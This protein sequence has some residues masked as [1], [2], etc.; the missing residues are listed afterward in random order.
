MLK[1]SGN[2]V[3]PAEIAA[4][5]I[6][7]GQAQEAEVIG[8]KSETGETQ[9]I[10]FV[11]P[12]ASHDATASGSAQNDASVNVASA[13]LASGV[14][15]NAVATANVATANVA[16]ANVVSAVSTRSLA[17]SA[18]IASAASTQAESNLRRLLADRL[19]T[20]MIPRRIV[21]RRSFPRTASGKV[22][23]PALLE[24]LK[25]HAHS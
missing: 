11:V 14:A 4:Q 19:P 17:A 15:A 12:T 7:T 13:T 22:D 9:V 3:Y 10:A 23:R 1:I 16:T 24:L 21:F 5:I 18:D 6:A 8:V 20:Y 2:R 25:P